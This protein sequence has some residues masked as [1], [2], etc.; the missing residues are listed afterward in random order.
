LD[1]ALGLY[2]KAGPERCADRILAIAEWLAE[3]LRTRGLTRYGSTEPDHASGIVTVAPDAPEA[4]FE[5]LQSHGITA[6]LR[7]R[8][9]RFSP[10]YYNDESDL[11]TVL[12]AVD[13]FQE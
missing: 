1:A 3:E 10:S 7:N 6:A 5:H 4:L 8:K 13:A 2:L 11:Q 9:L 12:D